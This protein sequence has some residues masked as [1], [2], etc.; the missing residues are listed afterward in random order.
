MIVIRVL[1]SIFG[2]YYLLGL[3]LDLLTSIKLF[4]PYQNP[5]T[6]IIFLFTVVKSAC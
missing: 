6:A 1:I 2:I 3:E 4:D 5:I